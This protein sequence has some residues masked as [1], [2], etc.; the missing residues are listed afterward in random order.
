M[1]KIITIALIVLIGSCSKDD[2]NN[3]ADGGQTTNPSGI[4]IGDFRD[5][6]VVFWIDPDDTNH[7]LVCAINDQSAGAEWGCNST[8][9][10]SAWRKFIGGGAQNTEAIFTNCST[11]S[12]AS[13]I[14][15]NLTLN[16]YSDWFL[17]SKD[18]LNA[19]EVNRIK[20]N[21]ISLANGGNAFT[22]N[23]YWSSTQYTNIDQY[24][25]C[26]K[27]NNGVSTFNDK[28]NEYAVRCI[29]AF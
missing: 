21:E 20:I 14:A 7:G 25:Y 12:T 8:E 2:E 19:I 6:G 11:G 23:Y 13:D 18:E 17:P 27:L 26:Q 5:G 24:A 4:E 15:S 3:E 10:T 22:I 1:K 16:G 9:I 29:R 28:Y